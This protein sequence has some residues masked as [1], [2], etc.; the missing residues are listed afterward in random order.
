MPRSD[1]FAPLEAVGVAL[2]VSGGHAVAHAP[3]QLDLL[4]ES[5]TQMYRARPL[6]PVRY[7][8]SEF[9]AVLMDTAVAVVLAP[10]EYA[11]PLAAPEFAFELELLLL[12]PH[13]ATMIATPTAAPSLPA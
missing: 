4:P 13:A 8:P 1:A 12:E 6:E 3:E 9:F 2:V 7:V 11:E 10:L 5:A